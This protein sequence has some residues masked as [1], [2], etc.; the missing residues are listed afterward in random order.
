M[1][2]QC[3]RHLARGLLYR[4]D[5]ERAQQEF[6][7]YQ[8]IGTGEEL[9]YVE[10][11]LLQ[12]KAREALA[13]IDTVSDEDDYVVGKLHAGRAMALFS[14]GKTAEADAVLAELIAMQIMDQR[15][16]TLL[17]AQV[18][19]WM[20]K[21]DQAFEKL[22]EMSA[23]N[24]LTLRYRMFSPIWRGLHDDPRWLELR[25]FNRISAERLDAIE[26]NPDLPK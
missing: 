1:C 18:A 22:F 9:Y 6:G 10:I 14:L 24:F 23:T 21:N 26:F 11:L 5:Y 16:Q 19:A 2:H 3:R 8:A 7:R 15:Y 4:R 20:G 17:A 12:G 25:E 13:Y